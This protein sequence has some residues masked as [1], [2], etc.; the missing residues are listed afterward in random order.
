MLDELE[1]SAYMREACID[2]TS[3][4]KVPTCFINVSWGLSAVV[5]VRKF[6]IFASNRPDDLSWLSLILEAESTL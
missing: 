5:I 6:W 3:K 4:A 1:Y 2:A